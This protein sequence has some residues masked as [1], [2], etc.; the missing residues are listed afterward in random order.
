MGMYINIGNDGF[1]AIRKGI[2]VDKSGLIAYINK[3][4]GTK[5]K[6][7]CTSRPRRFGKSYTT[8]MLS[9][10]YDKSCDSDKLFCDLKIAGDGSYKKHLN[11]YN[12]I[13][14]DI[15]WFI[16]TVGNIKNTVKYLQEEVIKELKE[17]FP[18]IPQDI[19]LLPV[20]LSYIN[21]SAGNKFVILIDEWDALFR[22]A[23]DNDLLQKEYIQLLRG[24]F[25]SSQTDK[26]IEAA[27]MTGIYQLRNM[28]PS[29]H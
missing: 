16:S 2:Y 7:V 27:Y 18:G 12:V 21:K 3:T 14:L 1:A 19:K 23:K 5:D 22:E 10:Y 28:V 17:M 20:A 4:F 26:I 24:L 29:L 11:K 8:Q 25:K 13:Y 6:L 9:A 15:T